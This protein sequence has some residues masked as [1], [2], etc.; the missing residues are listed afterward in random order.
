MHLSPLV[1]IVLPTYNRSH[2]LPRAIASVS[3]QTYSHFELIVVDDGSSDGTLAFLQRLRDTRTRFIRLD[4]NMGA[5]R[6]RNLGIRQSRGELIAFLDSD[7][8][9]HPTKLE[10]QLALITAAPPNVGAVG[11]GREIR[12]QGENGIT[13]ILRVPKL[14]IGN[15]YQALLNGDAFPGTP[16]WPGGTPAIM[17]RSECFKTIGLFDE[18]LPAA[19]EHDLYIR[20][21]RNYDFVAV[22][23]ILVTVH[24]D[25]VSRISTGVREQVSGK[26][27]LLEKYRDEIPI[28]SSLRANFSFHIGIRLFALGKTKEARRYLRQAVL[29]NPLARKYWYH[30]IRT[31]LPRYMYGGT[32]LCSTEETRRA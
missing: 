2:L 11:A 8:E 9:W 14:E 20:F 21:S 16:L 4:K 32:S 7:D 25:A 30:L 22:P 3:S 5:C 27:Q 31:A 29:S 1:S 18:S 26:R 13:T 12:I 28:F 17:F 23:E 6:A 19:Q 10:K 15:I 24:S